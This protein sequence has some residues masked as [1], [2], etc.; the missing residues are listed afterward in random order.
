LDRAVR[1]HAGRDRGRRRHP[2]AAMSERH[3]EAA[4]TGSTEQA[5]PAAHDPDHHADISG[6]WLRPAVFGAMDGLVT[7]IALIAGVGGGGVDRSRIILTGLAGLVA[8]AFSM[9][10]GEYTSV[11]SQNE[12]VHAE[13]ELERQQLEA[14]PKGEQEELAEALAD[15]GIDM[16]LARQVAA[17]VSKHPDEALRLHAQAELGV[18]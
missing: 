8:G 10:T 12:L 5:P 6:G 2:H 16:T 11:T 13:V 17:Q 15:K 14:N 3:T 9:A 4:V 7:N 18:D 1:A